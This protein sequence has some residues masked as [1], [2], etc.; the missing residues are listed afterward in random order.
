MIIQSTIHYLTISQRARDGMKGRPGLPGTPGNRGTPGTPGTAG[1]PGT[2]SLD[3][4]D[5]PKPIISAW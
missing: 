5:T 3:I 1:T 2:L 4:L